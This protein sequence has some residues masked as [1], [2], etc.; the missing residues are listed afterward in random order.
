MKNNKATAK[1]IGQEIDIDIDPFY[2]MMEARFISVLEWDQLNPFWDILRS[3]ADAGWYVYAVGEEPPTQTC[4]AE[5]IETFIQEVDVLL[6]KDHQEEYCGI[7]Y[8]DNKSDPTF[9][10]IYDPNNL[11]VSCGFSDNPPPPGWIL[12]LIPPCP[13]KDNPLLPANRRNWWQKIW[14]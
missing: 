13:V 4:N 9:V 8:A 10:K 7:V 11:G 14:D 2:Q 5:H 1:E 6:R 3:K 12:S